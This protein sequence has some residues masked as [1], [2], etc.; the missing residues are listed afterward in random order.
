MVWGGGAVCSLALA[1]S[2][3]WQ[4]ATRPPHLS[5]PHAG[6]AGSGSEPSAHWDCWCHGGSSLPTTSLG[7][8]HLWLRTKGQGFHFFVELIHALFS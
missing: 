2:H 1:G 8:V 6:G 5:V 7:A 3:K 4:E